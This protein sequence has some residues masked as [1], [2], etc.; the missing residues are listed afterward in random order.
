MKGPEADQQKGNRHRQKRR[1]QKTDQRSTRQ[2]IIGNDNNAVF[3]KKI[4]NIRHHKA[5]I[6]MKNRPG[7]KNQKTIQQIGQNIAC[8]IAEI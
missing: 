2:H 7:M 4:G 5:K 6:A 8:Q 1:Y 3:Q